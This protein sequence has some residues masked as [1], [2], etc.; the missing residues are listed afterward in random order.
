MGMV[1]TP[2][3]PTVLTCRA[4]S[5][6]KVTGLQAPGSPIHQ[7]SMAK[8]LNLVNF[9]NIWFV[10]GL[11]IHMEPSSRLLSLYE[12]SVGVLKDERA[13]LPCDAAA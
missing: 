4:N 3:I 9:R 8:A 10:L 5:I 12:P 2:V 7:K 13:Q 1:C 11:F 6:S